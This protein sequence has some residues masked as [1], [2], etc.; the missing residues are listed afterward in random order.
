LIVT[1]GAA[2]APITTYVWKAQE[3]EVQRQSQA[4]TVHMDLL[5]YLVGEGK[6]GTDL[7]LHR[8]AVLDFFGQYAKNV[9]KDEDLLEWIETR[10]QDTLK[11]L[12]ATRT[13]EEARGEQAA[14]QAELQQ[15][16]MEAEETKAAAK[17]ELAGGTA[18]ARRLELTRVIEQSNRESVAVQSKIRA[19]AGKVREATHKLEEV[20]KAPTRACTAADVRSS[21]ASY[22]TLCTRVMPA[23]AEH[24]ASW[25]VKASDHTKDGA[26]RVDVAC[27]C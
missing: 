13:T 17:A 20:T 4:H 1:V 24:G 14:I 21:S 22:L 19:V 16:A 7:L 11:A 26:T 6:S 18:A 5:K 9:L 8:L 25:H 2:V 15:Q 10:T 12:R 23:G 27:S 3:Q